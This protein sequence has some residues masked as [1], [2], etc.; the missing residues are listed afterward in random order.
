LLGDV[1]ANLIG[2]Y[3]FGVGRPGWNSL[4]IGA[5][6][7]VTV[8]GDILLIPRHGAVGAAIASC[9]AYLA[10]DIALLLFFR[11]SRPVS[12]QPLEE[13]VLVPA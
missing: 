1:V 4:A 7:L 5:G 3:L 12:D 9:V 8:V 2:A 11:A 13:D 6:V 10:T